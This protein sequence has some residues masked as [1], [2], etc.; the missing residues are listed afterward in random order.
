MNPIAPSHILLTLVNYELI[1]VLGR[2]DIFHERAWIKSDI[3]AVAIKCVVETRDSPHAQELKDELFARYENVVWGV[4]SS[5][6]R[7]K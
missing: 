4:R 6:G 5:D 1:N 3:Y 7:S 2:Q